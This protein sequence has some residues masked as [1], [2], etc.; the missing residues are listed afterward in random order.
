MHL[1]EWIVFADKSSAKTEDIAKV[2][3]RVGANYIRFIQYFVT[4]G[5]SRFG[6]KRKSRLSEIKVRHQL[7]FSKTFPKLLLKLYI[8]MFGKLLGMERWLRSFSYDVTKQHY[9][10]VISFASIWC[11]LVELLRQKCVCRLSKLACNGVGIN[12]KVRI[13]ARFLLR[14]T[15]VDMNQCTSKR[16][17]SC[18]LLYAL[19]C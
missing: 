10:K 14:S 17:R 6:F 15:S 7:R 5:K 8:W 19:H 1:N 9:E 4:F 16:H 12:A 2:E 18:L 3:L 11:C 13:A